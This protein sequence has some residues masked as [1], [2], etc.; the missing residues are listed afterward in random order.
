MK[1]EGITEDGMATAADYGD[2]L[3]AV[4]RVSREEYDDLQAQ[5]KNLLNETVV[6]Q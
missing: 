6:I 3:L 5:A 2:Y 1:Q 4:K